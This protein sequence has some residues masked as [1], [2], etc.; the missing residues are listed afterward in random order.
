MNV[1]L[2]REACFADQFGLAS[3]RELSLGRGESGHTPLLGVLTDR[4]APLFKTRRYP[5]H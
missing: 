1:A 2:S 3:V 4:Q 5:Q